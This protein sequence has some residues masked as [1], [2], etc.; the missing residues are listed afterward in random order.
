MERW[1]LLTELD[2]KVRHLGEMDRSMESLR[3]QL[4]KAIL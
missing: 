1:K 2:E 4:F 3:A